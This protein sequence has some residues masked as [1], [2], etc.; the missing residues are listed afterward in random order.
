MDN[1]IFVTQK[2]K[3]DSNNNEICKHKT[4]VLNNFIICKI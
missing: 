1:K 2:Y 3:I 4:F